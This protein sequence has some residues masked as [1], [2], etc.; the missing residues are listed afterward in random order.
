MVTPDCHQFV[1]LPGADRLVSAA[2]VATS[3][4][5]LPSYGRICRAHSTI[6]ASLS[7]VTDAG[8]ALGRQT[9]AARAGGAGEW[10]HKDGS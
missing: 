9:E 5:D 7:R 2:V 4:P 3:S 6:S 1:N 8:T 10:S